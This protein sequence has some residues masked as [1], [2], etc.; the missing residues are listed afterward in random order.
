MAACFFS[1]K[2]IRS[3]FAKDSVQYH[4]LVGYADLAQ[5][6]EDAVAAA[7]TAKNS[8]SSPAALAATQA[9][10]PTNAALPLAAAPKANRVLPQDVD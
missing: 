5:R 1:L 9:V 10:T 3:D 8:G 7:A 2:R 6:L 4:F